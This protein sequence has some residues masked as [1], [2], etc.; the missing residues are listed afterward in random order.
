[1]VRCGHPS[2]GR[3]AD[4]GL[5]Q[6]PHTSHVD[7]VFLDRDGT[8]NVKAA[9]GQYIE[10]PSDLV[11][12]PGAATAIARLNAAGVRVIL[13]TNQRWLSR[14]SADFAA[15]AAVQARLGE[16]LDREGARLDAAFYCPHGL[17]MCDCRKPGAGMLKQAVRERG[18]NFGSSVIIGDAA[19]DLMAGRSVG[20]GTVLLDAGMSA[21]P[22]ADIVTV[23]LAHAV[24]FLLDCC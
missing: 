9:E 24:S 23:D 8:I 1:M 3:R 14:P 20:M 7:T 21:H 2:A 15:F 11:L 22:L 18:G 6:L 4:G 12:L 16:L 19:S 10:R 13:V 5:I 17:G